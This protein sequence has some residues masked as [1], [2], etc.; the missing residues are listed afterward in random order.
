MPEAAHRALGF[1]SK[2]VPL[3]VWLLR[4]PREDHLAAG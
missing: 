2:P 3:S 1:S 4:G